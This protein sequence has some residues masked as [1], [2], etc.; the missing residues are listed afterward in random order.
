MSLSLFKTYLEWRHFWGYHICF[1]ERGWKMW[2]VL[3]LSMLA[4]HAFHTRSWNEAQIE[5]LWKMARKI[6]D[7]GKAWIRIPLDRVF[8]R[9][10]LC[11]E[12]CRC[13]T[14]F[15]RRE[16]DFATFTWAKKCRREKFWFR[17]AGSKLLC[18]GNS[19]LYFD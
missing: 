14:H 2:R 15:C 13:E 8:W 12:N 17:K 10:F 7:I 11:F 1:D 9:K 5:M 18:R 16:I 3:I 19:W 4:P 6:F